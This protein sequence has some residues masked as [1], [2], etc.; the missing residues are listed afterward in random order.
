M[1][2]LATETNPLSEIPLFAKLTPQELG[3]LASL[4]KPR[5]FKAGNTIVLVG[6]PGQEFFLIREGRVAISLPDDEG[7]EVVLAS[8]GPGHFFGEIS[9][10]DGGPRTATASAETDAVLWE[11]GRADFLAFIS[12]HPLVAI[13]MMTVLGRRQRE[14]NEKLRAIK[15]VNE[16]IAEQRTVGELAAQRLAT[17]FASNRFVLINLVFFAGWIVSNVVLFKSHRNFDDPPTFS[18]LGFVITLESILL[19]MFVLASQKFQSERDRVRADL[20]Y[21]V[22]VKAQLDIV[23][24]HQKVDR[25]QSL[26]KQA[27]IGDGDQNAPPVPKTLA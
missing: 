18:T 15:N 7:K 11:L 14:T 12:G 5:Q 9:L 27:A 3:E 22:N 24:L 4:L 26:M 6:L 17:A 20:E 13:Q 21:Q 23:E 2:A 1:M 19:S 8:L 25:L 10:L 16:V